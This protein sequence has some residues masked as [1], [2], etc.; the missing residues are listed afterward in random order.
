MSQS[1]ANLLEE[2]IG[3]I[4]AGI[5]FEFLYFQ[6]L[7]EVFDSLHFSLLWSIFFWGLLIVIIV[8]I[9]LR[10][11]KHVMRR[12]VLFALGVMG[13]AYEVKDWYSFGIAIVGLILLVW[14]RRYV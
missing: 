8:A 9:G 6:W 14:L 1:G 4:F 13:L 11:L 12:G 5:V 10:D 7:P 3:F 2:V